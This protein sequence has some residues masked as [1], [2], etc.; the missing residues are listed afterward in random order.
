MAK[1]KKSLG[2]DV[3]SICHFIL[4]GIYWIVSSRHAI[5]LVASLLAQMGKNPPAVQETQVQSLGQKG[6][7]EGEMATHASLLAW[8]IPW[9][10]ELGRPQFTGSQGV[11][12]NWATISFTFS[13]IIVCMC[14]SQSPNSSHPP[15]LSPLVSIY[16]FSMS[17]FLLCK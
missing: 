15:P 6:L 10:E 2:N 14:Q 9:T 3:L 5:S 1:V 8:R 12:H 13:S 4:N 16:L 11:G 7:L 17:P